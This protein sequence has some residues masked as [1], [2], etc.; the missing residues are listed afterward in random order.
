MTDKEDA[1]IEYFRATA[2]D[3]KRLSI[4]M[5]VISGLCFAVVITSLIYVLA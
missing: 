3:A 2:R 5:F 4:A 1:L